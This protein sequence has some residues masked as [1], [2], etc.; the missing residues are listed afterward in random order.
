[1][2]LEAGVHSSSLIAAMFNITQNS[3]KMDNIQSWAST[4]GV[5]VIYMLIY[6]AGRGALGDQPGLG[7]NDD[8]DFSNVVGWTS[9]SSYCSA[10]PITVP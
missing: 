9:P 2:C 3:T 7:L 6:Q 1:M 10:I 4:Y 5:L 8:F